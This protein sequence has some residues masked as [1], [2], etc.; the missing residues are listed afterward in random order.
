MSKRQAVEQRL[1]KFFNDID[2]SGTNAGIYKDKIFK[3]MS[4]KDFDKFM[5]DLRDKKRHLVIYAPN[6]SKVKLDLER[7]IKLGE[8]R[9]HNFFPRLW[10]EGKPG[11]RSYLSPVPAFVIPTRLRRQAQLATKGVSVPD[12]MRT[13][14]S[15][16][17]QPTG[18]SKSARLSLPEIQL[19][20]SSGL[21]KSMEEL[22]KYRGGDVRGGAALQNMLVRFGQASLENLKPFS[23]GVE[24]TNYVKALFTGAH[25]KVNL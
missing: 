22:I 15:L 10:T 5:H 16:T 2:P 25:L 24:S 19:C 21:M 6:Y 1:L 8:K 20:G 13:I 3:D 23:S 7:N 14:N 11:V 18:D 9:G 4:D 17:G 12:N